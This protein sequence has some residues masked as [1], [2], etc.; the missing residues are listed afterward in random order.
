MNDNR[1]CIILANFL[2]NRCVGNTV[3]N[4]ALVSK[5]CNFMLSFSWKKVINLRIFFDNYYLIKILK[6]KITR[7]SVFSYQLSIP[8]T[9]NSAQ[10]RSNAN[11]EYPILIRVP[12]ISA[13][14]FRFHGGFFSRR[15][16]GLFERMLFLIINFLLYFSCL[17]RFRWVSHVWFSK[18]RPVF[19]FIMTVLH[20]C[21]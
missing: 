11:P 7:K 14:S 3:C 8:E 10:T 6:Q 16:L 2:S 18:N 9:I 13:F 5:S 12:L 1:K 21:D 20:R 19:V 15:R 4:S 17:I